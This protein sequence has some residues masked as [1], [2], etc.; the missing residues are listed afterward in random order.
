M[1][2]RALSSVLV[3]CLLWTVALAAQQSLQVVSL[4]RD[5][6]V[7]VTFKLADA[8]N[9][10]VRAAIQSG[11]TTSFVYDIELK[12]GSTMW[13]DRT[14]ASTTLTASVRFDNLTRR[15][16]L[17]RSQDGRIDRAENTDREEDARLWLTEFDRLPLFSSASLEANAEYYLR[18][19]AHATPRSASFVWPWGRHDVTGHVTFTFLK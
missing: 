15:Y 3:C 9:E 18:V 7:L 4:T 2:S 8:F 16:F 11:M 14:I 1:K 10:D 12:R 6:R 5:G 13:L 17:S 19:R